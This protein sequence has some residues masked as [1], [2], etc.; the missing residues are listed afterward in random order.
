MIAAVINWSL[1]NRVLV[2]LMTALMVAGGVYAI[3]TTPIDALPDLSDVQVI[4]KGYL[5]RNSFEKVVIY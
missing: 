4:I 2:L 5:R 3:K 1:Q